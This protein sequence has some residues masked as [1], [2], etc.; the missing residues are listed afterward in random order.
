MRINKDFFVYNENF[1]AVAS[2]A[3]AT[4]SINIQADSDFVL[5]KLTYFADIASAAQTDDS[6]VIPLCSMQ[7]TD[8]GSGRQL[9]EF[10][11][12]VASIFGTGQLPFI[13]PTPKL[14]PARSTITINVAN[15][16]DSTD[17]NLKFAFIGYKVFNTGMG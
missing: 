9:F 3:S 14:F 6:R 16:S 17:Y 4:G 11:T 2:G 5:Q 8:S 1:D 12:P 13:L 7:I 15:F 10:A